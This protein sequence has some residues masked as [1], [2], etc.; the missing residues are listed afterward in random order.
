MQLRERIYQTCPLCK[1]NGDMISDE[2]YGCDQ[3]KK[4]MDLNKP[5]Y[6]YISATVHM[7]NDTTTHLEF[8]SWR[9]CLT[10]LRTVKCDNFISL[11][12]LHYSDSRILAKDFFKLVKR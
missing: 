10:H 1:R 8:C 11:P 7:R 2:V 9:C 4:V 3:C 5:E 12:F 6:D